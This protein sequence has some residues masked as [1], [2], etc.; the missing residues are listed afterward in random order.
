MENDIEHCCV[1]DLECALD[2]ESSAWAQKP[3]SAKRPTRVSRNSGD[4]AW[5]SEWV[6][7]DLRDQRE[8][9]LIYPLLAIRCRL[10]R[11]FI[12]VLRPLCDGE[13]Q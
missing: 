5:G 13:Q 8:L 11:F 4:C 1:I 6:Q 2:V 3:G 12:P 10:D 7:G 9:H